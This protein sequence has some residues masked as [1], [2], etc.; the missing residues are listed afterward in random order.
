MI[1]LAE[2]IADR[3]GQVTGQSTLDITPEQVRAHAMSSLYFFSRFVLGFDHMQTN[4]HAELCTLLAGLG[5]GYRSLR[6]TMPRGA[7]KTTLASKA[8]PMWLSIN[9]PNL[10]ILVVAN[11]FDNACMMVSEIRQQWDTNDT[12]RGLFPELLVEGRR[13]KW[14]DECATIRRTSTQ[15]E[16]TYN[17]AGVGTS[18]PSRHYHVMVCDDLVRAQ[19]NNATGEEFQPDQADIEKAILFIKML[20]GLWVKSIERLELHVGTRWAVHDVIRWL[21]DTKRCEKTYEIAAVDSQGQPTYP[22]KYPLHE[23]KR[24]E[25]SDAMGP[26]MF[27]TQYMNKP[28]ALEDQ[29]FPTDKLLHWETLPTELAFSM[30]IDPASSKKASADYTAINIVGRHE[31]TDNWYIVEAY[32]GKLS[33][34]ETVDQ[35]LHLHQKWNVDQIGVETVGYQEALREGLQIESDQRALNDPSFNPPSIKKLKTPNNVTKEQRIRGLQP[36][37]MRNVS[38]PEDTTSGIFLAPGMESLKREVIEFPGNLHEDALDALAYQR[39][40]HPSN[41]VRKETTYQE[42]MTYWYAMDQVRGRIKRR[43]RLAL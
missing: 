13:G 23:L 11:T 19:I 28:R 1:D 37:F 38:C 25:G 33:P 3:I 17:A 2:P 32:R 26:Y 24:I 39:Q 22:W 34:S 21:N 43:K 12:L 9:N 20:D 4:P 40:L 14:S 6:V 27:A 31:P 41:I 30:T 18:L 16:G 36:R 7:L 10:S 5:N 42:H 8:Y 29:I 35:I 15:G